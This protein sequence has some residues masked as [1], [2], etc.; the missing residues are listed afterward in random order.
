VQEVRTLLVLG[1]A[2]IAG[3]V[4]D[5]FLNFYV[6]VSKKVVEGHNCNQGYAEVN[7]VVSSPLLCMDYQLLNM[8]LAIA[9]DVVHYALV[10][11]ALAK[12][13]AGRVCFLLGVCVCVCV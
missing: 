8:N 4:Y 12:L 5:K 11:F 1:P 7:K 9:C 13:T 10:D 3:V 2:T 6:D